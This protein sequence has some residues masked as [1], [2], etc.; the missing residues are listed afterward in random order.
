MAYEERRS[1]EQVFAPGVGDVADGSV[2]Y[3]GTDWE[4]T[5]EPVSEAEKMPRSFVCGGAPEPACED[6][7]PRQTDAEAYEIVTE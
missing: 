5:K 7:Q 3:Y 2:D 6:N 1:D 4:N